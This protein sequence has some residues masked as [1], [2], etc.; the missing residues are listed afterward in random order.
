MKLDYNTHKDV[1]YEWM[2]YVAEFLGTTFQLELIES[3]RDIEV[4]QST[5][6][7]PIEV[8]FSYENRIST[9]LDFLGP[10]HITRQKSLGKFRKFSG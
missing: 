6:N 4:F 5:F 7:S 2:S 9:E 10:A 8:T 3:K 1:C